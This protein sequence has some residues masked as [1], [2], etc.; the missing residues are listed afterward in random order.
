MSIRVMSRVW[1]YS[2]QVGGDLLLLLA[3]ADFADDD[4]Y[5]WPKQDQ[6]AAKARC[7]VRAVRDQLVRLTAAGEIERSD[8][9]GRGVGSTYRVLT[10]MAES[11]K[12][13]GVAAFAADKK[14]QVEARK[15]AIRRT[16]NRQVATEKP[17][18]LC[19]PIENHQEPSLRPVNDPSEEEG[20][21]T[22]A[23]VH[24]RP[25]PKP[26]PMKATAPSPSSVIDPDD[27]MQVAFLEGCG[28]D[29]EL[30]RS[31]V[32]ISVADYAGRLKRR[33]F[34]AAEVREAAATWHEFLPHRDPEDLEPPHPQQLAEWV[35]RRRASKAMASATSR[36][37]PSPR[38]LLVPFIET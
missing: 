38:H 2:E 8:G 4:G 17:A 35:A 34:T 36:T 11:G 28:L 33:K 14:R 5:C 19:R 16:N 10:G 7:S 13:A 31:S 30:T 6:L 37:R 24:T 32:L 15:A 3:L 22:S 25:A 29:P 23:P 27:E 12:A 18:T 9:R 26:G 1:D 20:S 21:R